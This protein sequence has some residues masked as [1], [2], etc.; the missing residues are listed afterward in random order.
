[1]S[2]EE[3]FAAVDKLKAD[4]KRVADALHAHHRELSPSSP[5]HAPLHRLHRVVAD[6][7]SVLALTPRPANVG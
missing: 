7:H 6:F 4:S 3:I 1:M 5:A 2:L